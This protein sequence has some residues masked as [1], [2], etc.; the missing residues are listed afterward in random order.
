VP[1][2]PFLLTG[3]ALG[4]FVGQPVWSAYLG[5]VGLA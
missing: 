1:H 4:L 2:G 3:A 5:M